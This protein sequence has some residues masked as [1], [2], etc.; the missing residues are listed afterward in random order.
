MSRLAKKH[1]VVPDKVEIIKQGVAGNLTIKGPKGEIGFVLHKAVKMHQDG[2][3]VRFELD[4]EAVDR[5]M[6]LYAMLGTT[7]STFANCL[8]GVSEGYKIGL[9]II[10]V[11]YRAKVQGNILD[12]TVGHSHPDPFSIP[13]GLKISVENNNIIW[14][15]GASKEQVTQIAA[16]IMA[17]R[18]V[19][20][21][22]GK[23]IRYLGQKV[24]FKQS[25]KAKKK[26]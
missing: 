24:I 1:L 19:E 22:K 2:N 7:V 6:K 17:L 12:M 16:N 5:D 23:G 20:P 11:G 26:G 18:P 10:G 3:Q 15:E 21:Y 25:T 14:I 4:D 8:R 13:N 9:E